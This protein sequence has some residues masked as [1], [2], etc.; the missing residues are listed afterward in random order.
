MFCF[1]FFV[2]CRLF[3]FSENDTFFMV[4][5]A[6]WFLGAAH[7]GLGNK[8]HKQNGAG[9]TWKRDESRGVFS[10]IGVKSTEDRASLFFFPIEEKKERSVCISAERSR[11]ALENHFPM[12]RV[13]KW[14][15]RLSREI[16]NLHPCRPLKK[17]IYVNY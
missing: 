2:K 14:R 12:V 13:L 8:A 9:S 16:C 6:F 11:L 4:F 15:N 7:D 3:C 1:C 5:N 17:S 10:I